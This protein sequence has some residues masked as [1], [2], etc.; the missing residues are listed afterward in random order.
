MPIRATRNDSRVRRPASRPGA[1][2]DSL[3][4]QELKRVSG[5][6]VAGVRRELSLARERTELP[7]E[8][9]WNAT[10]IEDVDFH[11]SDLSGSKVAG[12]VLR[13][14]VRLSGCTFR[15]VDLQQSHFAK[16][17]LAHCRL[18]R[19]S[20]VDSRLEGVTIV[21]C[22]LD[23][24]DLRGTR[25]TGAK[26]SSTKFNAS[27]FG[28]TKFGNA[29]LTDVTFLAGSGFAYFVGCQ[30]TRVDFS[31]AVFDDLTFGHTSFR[32]VRF[33]DSGPWLALR[34]RDLAE[35]FRRVMPHVSDQTSNYLTRILGIMVASGDPWVVGPSVLEPLER[36]EREALLA[37]LQPFAIRTY[38]TGDK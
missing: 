21:D 34:S 37:A 3:V 28:R 38:S 24:A 9:N 7:V 20:L 27:R 5:P 36:S 19:S 14:R 32:E 4:L 30:L 11:D 10:L 23:H 12:G 26:V 22:N 1:V 2:P 29:A 6:N 8:L 15:G 16:V 18:D 33:P 25:L 31:Q 13:G 17:D 35:G